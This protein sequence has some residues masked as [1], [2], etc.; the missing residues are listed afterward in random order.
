[1]DQDVVEQFKLTFSTITHPDNNA[2]SMDVSALTRGLHMLKFETQTCAFPASSGSQSNHNDYA[3]KFES[4]SYI[5]SL[6]L[7]LLAVG[8]LG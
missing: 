2:A 8:S 5:F 7:S 4:Q 6:L 1:M 3:V